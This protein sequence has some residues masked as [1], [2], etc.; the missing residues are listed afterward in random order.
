M[1]R[2]LLERTFPFGK[3]IITSEALAQLHPEDLHQALQ[4]NAGGDRGD[5]PRH[6]GTDNDLAPNEGSILVS[7]YR[8][9]NHLAFRILTE[10]D[11][12]VTCVLLPEDD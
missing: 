7:E 6:H 9:R 11:H 10:L 8:D 4:R 5:I 12:S 3:V 1:E 2:R